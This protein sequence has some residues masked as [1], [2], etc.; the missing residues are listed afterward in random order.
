MFTLYRSVVRSL[1]ASTPSADMTAHTSTP[2]ISQKHNQ[3]GYRKPTVEDFDEKEEE[4]HVERRTD[5]GTSD[6][7]DLSE[8]GD[9]FASE[10]DLS[11]RGSDTTGRDSE[12]DEPEEEEKKKNREDEKRR[13][14]KEQAEEFLRAAPEGTSAR[15][16]ELMEK[17]ARGEEV[18]DSE[19][20]LKTE[21]EDEKSDDDMDQWEA[22]TKMAKEV[23]RRH[24]E[25]L[26]K[27]WLAKLTKEDWEYAEEEIED[28]IRI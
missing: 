6:K 17:L 22:K 28:M 2:S 23:K 3:A 7:Y 13:M 18:E 12:Q 19:E 16:R 9:Y 25:E 21:S 1:Q 11:P 4:V 14:M 8:K 26:I 27:Y 5:A 20:D 24:E 15:V 10:F